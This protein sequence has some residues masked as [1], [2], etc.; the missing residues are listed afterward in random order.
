MCLSVSCF[1]LV[2]VIL[3]TSFLLWGVFLCCT[4]LYAGYRV[5]ALLRNM[6]GIL[7]QRDTGAS[8]YKGTSRQESP[9]LLISPAFEI[10]STQ[11]YIYC[12][13]VHFIFTVGG[14][15]EALRS[16]TKNIYLNHSTFEVN[17][18]KDNTTIL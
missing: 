8:Q 12:N 5:M 11:S 10:K 13:F 2:R 18:S 17:L 14:L 15:E 7:F 1:Q 9:Y 6:S 16:V 3:E 4:F